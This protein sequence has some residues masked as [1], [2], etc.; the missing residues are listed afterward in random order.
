MGARDPARW[1]PRSHRPGAGF[2]AP[3]PAPERLLTI[4]DPASRP[5]GNS[6][7]DAYPRTPAAVR[8]ETRHPSDAEPPVRAGAAPR[9]VR[10]VPRA[11]PARG[12]RVRA[13]LPESLGS[14]P[15]PVYVRP[16]CGTTTIRA[17]TAY[18]RKHLA[19]LKRRVQ[20]LGYWRPA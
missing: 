2:D 11:G 7:L 18:P 9:D 14:D 1:H 16:A 19:L 10:R 13:E 20:G 4:G 5:A 17:L 3:V 12:G 15:A 6:L 8:F